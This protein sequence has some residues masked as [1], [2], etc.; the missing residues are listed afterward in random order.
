MLPTVTLKDVR[1]GK[2][3]KK[4]WDLL[5]WL[6]FFFSSSLPLSENAWKS[7][8]LRRGTSTTDVCGITD[9]AESKAFSARAWQLL[10]WPKAGSLDAAVTEVSSSPPVDVASVSLPLASESCSFPAEQPAL[11]HPEGRRAEA[12]P[13]DR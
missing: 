5:S 9:F 4:Y 10:P 11:A 2:G 13:P 3:T 8:V 1:F 12:P 6:F 7:S